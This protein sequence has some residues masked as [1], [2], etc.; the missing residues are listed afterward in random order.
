MTTCITHACQAL[1]FGGRGLR[2]RDAKSEASEQYAREKA[3]LDAINTARMA[4]GCDCESGCRLGTCVCAGEGVDC[5]DHICRC[6][7]EACGNPHGKYVFLEALVEAVRQAKL[8]SKPR[9]GKGRN[10]KT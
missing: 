6:I 5:H 10:K 4:V 1:L 7:G 2:A 9:K 3:D 8:P